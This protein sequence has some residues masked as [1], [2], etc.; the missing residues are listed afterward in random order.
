MTGTDATVA[1]QG[2]W[3]DGQ[4]A[5]RQA[6]TVQIIGNTQLKLQVEGSERAYALAGLR[7]AERWRDGPAPLALPDGSTLWLDESA[8]LLLDRLPASYGSLRVWRDTVWRLMLV[9][10]VLVAL[11]AWLDRQGIGLL[12]QGAMHMLPRAVDEHMGGKV[13]EDLDA[14][15]LVASKVSEERQAALRVRF[16][17]A[18]TQLVPEVKVRLLFR[19]V[20][21]SGHDSQ[22][23]DGPDPRNFNAFAVP[24]GTICML[25][26][27]TEALSDD[28]VMAVLGH[29]LGHVVHRHAMNNIARSIGF[30]AFAGL[31]WG[32]GSAFVSVAS[33]GLQARR[34]S[35][36]AERQANAYARS[37]IAHLQLP[38][39]TLLSAF[40]KFAQRQ[41]S[42]GGEPPS[43][44]STHPDLD[45]RIDTERRLLSLP[46]LADPISKET[47]P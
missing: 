21:A 32:D 46:P 24:D 26:D 16:E 5:T 8:A 44:L 7:L 15:Q 42:S 18:A 22:S 34:Y 19:S 36:D 12:A 45:E 2:I 1:M 9:T 20:K 3:F 4:R 6:A 40:A 39:Q 28:E 43:W 41:A 11:L 27:L 47:R 30:L 10:V 38:P 25:D 14:E 35:R 29:E 23:D 17:T 13:F 33:S 31:V 37:F